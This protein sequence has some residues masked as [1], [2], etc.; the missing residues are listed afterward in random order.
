MLTEKHE[1]TEK[2]HTYTIQY[3]DGVVEKLDL[4]SQ[5]IKIIDG[6]V[7]I[8]SATFTP[9]TR[10]RSES[11]QSAGDKSGEGE[12]GHTVDCRYFAIA[13]EEAYQK[14]IKEHRNLK[15]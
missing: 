12:D 9:D 4:A 8:E 14:N 6:N 7:E 13:S 15:W 5:Q 11:F 10:I 1:S 2:P 3:K